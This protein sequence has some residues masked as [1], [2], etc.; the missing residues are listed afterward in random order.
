MTLTP[1]QINSIINPTVYTT[2]DLSND[3][4][5]FNIDPRFRIQS[6]IKQLEVITGTQR[7]GTDKIMVDIGIGQQSSIVSA[8]MFS[9]LYDQYKL[10]KQVD[11]TFKEFPSP[12]PQISLFVNTGGE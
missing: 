3:P 5:I 4:L 12:T 6:I 9:P 2:T 11:N 8:R 7:D 10:A 1:T